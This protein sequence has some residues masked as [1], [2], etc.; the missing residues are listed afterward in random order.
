MGSTRLIAGIAAAGVAI[1]VAGTGAAGAAAPSKTTIKA[2]Q[3]FKFKPN[4]YVQDGLRWNKDVYRIK[5]GGT[6]TVVNDANM[7][8]PHTLTAV[9]RKDLPKTVA[10]AFNCSA[11]NA[12]FLAHGADPNTDAPPKFQF[13][14]NGV[15]QVTAPQFDRPGD[16]GLTGDGQQKGERISFTVTAKKG[17]TLSLLCIIH[18][19]MQAKLKVVG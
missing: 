17:T 16:S 9:R 13:V 2:V 3:T 5:S 10:Q 14:E 18:P 1:A 19:W 4:R 8:G 6:L 7:E 15:G 12:M 11:C